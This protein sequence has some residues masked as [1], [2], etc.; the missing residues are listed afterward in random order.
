MLEENSSLKNIGLF[1]FKP[2][3]DGWVGVRAGRSRKWNGK[4]A[5]RNLE[6][7]GWFHRSSMLQHWLN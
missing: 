4:E 6:R 7:M 2:M 1:C 5:G 3:T